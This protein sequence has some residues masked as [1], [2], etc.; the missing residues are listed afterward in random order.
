MLYV[1]NLIVLVLISNVD[2]NF[3]PKLDDFK[4]KRS[5]NIGSKF[6]ILCNLL[7]GTKPFQFEWHKNNKII[8]NA[9]E[10]IGLENF[11]DKSLLVIDKLSSDDSGR[12]TCIVRNKYGSDSQSTE[13]IVKGLSYFFE[14]LFTF[15]IKVWRICYYYFKYFQHFRILSIHL[16]CF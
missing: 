1:C 9:N 10:N 2:A 8:S 13:L 12:Y 11:D 5:Q 15:A 6:T 14:N 16:D 4:P 3:S 7:E